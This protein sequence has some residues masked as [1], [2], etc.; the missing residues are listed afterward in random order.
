VHVPSRGRVFGARQVT[1]AARDH[2]Q[3][4]GKDLGHGSAFFAGAAH[5][6]RRLR[7]EEHDET[8]RANV[9]DP[10]E[11]GEHAGFID[12][13]GFMLWWPLSDDVRRSRR[14]RRVCR[15]II[16]SL[17]TVSLSRRAQKTVHNWCKLVK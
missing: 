4:F 16:S 5:E 1:V 12:P 11:L 17:R 13:P 9:C 7:S 3:P 14:P 8:V 2:E 10:P 6:V 15:V